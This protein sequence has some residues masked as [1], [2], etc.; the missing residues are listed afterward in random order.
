MSWQFWHSEKFVKV[1]CHKCLISAGKNATFLYWLIFHGP[2]RPMLQPVLWYHTVTSPTLRPAK[3]TLPYTK[4]S[5]KLPF[6]SPLQWRRFPLSLL[7]SRW[8]RHLETF[9][10]KFSKYFSVVIFNLCWVERNLPLLANLHGPLRPNPTMMA[11]SL[12]LHGPFRPMLQHAVWYHT[13]T[14][15]TLRPVK[16]MLP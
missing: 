8:L 6:S 1:F 13:V 4:S 5:G 11:L 9:L 3:R 12:H 7:M 16:M 10:M 2:F 15:L 14:S